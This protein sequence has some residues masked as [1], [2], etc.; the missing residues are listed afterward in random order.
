MR[1]EGVLACHVLKTSLC[2]TSAVLSS[3]YL[4]SAKMQSVAVLTSGGLDSCVLVGDLARDHTVHPLYVACNLAWEQEERLALDRFL[5]ALDAP[6]VKPVTVLPLPVAAL[7]GDHWSIT[8]RGIPAMGAPDDAV[9]LPG[10][11]ILLLAAAAVW[12]SRNS[13]EDIALGTLA[14]NVQNDATPAF[15]QD[16]ARLLS[17]G[18]A[19]HRVGILY[20][21]RS[22]TKADIIAASAD[23]PLHETLTCMAPT[24]DAEGVLHCGACA[25]CSARRAV[26]RQAGVADATRYGY[27]PGT[28]A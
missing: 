16:Y 23:L 19:P 27:A 24:H 18:L 15:F 9:E 17:T 21:L 7:Y 12:C 8:G 13:I 20:P 2:K 28:G 6:T 3:S 10:R 1:S 4:W 5:G 26:F 11:N 14:L 22:R 25:K